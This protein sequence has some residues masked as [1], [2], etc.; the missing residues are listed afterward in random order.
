MAS[1][2]DHARTHTQPAASSEEWMGSAHPAGDADFPAIHAE[3]RAAPAHRDTRSSRREWM[4]TL[5]GAVLLFAFLRG[6]VVQVYGIQSGS[7]QP[8][9]LAG[10]YVIVNNTL[11]GAAIPFTARRLPEMRAPRG[12]DVVVYRPAGYVPARDH[13]KRIIG[14]PGDTVGMLN[15]VV[16]RNGARLREPYAKPAD[17]EDMPLPKGGP[18]NFQWQLGAM[19]RSADRENYAPTRDNWGPLVVPRGHYLLLGDD[20]GHSID[21][22]HTGFVPRAEIR[23]KVLAV[24]WSSGVRGVRWSRI[25]NRP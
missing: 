20:R 18:Y 12:G 17:A 9:L 24:H 13:I 23:G 6:L 19:P 3:D 10:D 16:Y 8:T 15:G 7:M 1:S 25:G 5:A 11:F 2:L 21:T 22:R 14:A 4:Q